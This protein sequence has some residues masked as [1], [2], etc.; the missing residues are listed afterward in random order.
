MSTESPE[1]SAPD[2][3]TGSEEPSN[4]IRGWQSLAERRGQELDA[5]RAEAAA[6]KAALAAYEREGT[7]RQLANEFP[8]AYEA[9]ATRKGA[10]GP[11][12]R[13]TLEVLQATLEERPNR[14]DP[15]NP[16]KRP[17]AKAP[18]QM[19]E[20]ELRALIQATA[21]AQGQ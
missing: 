12:D 10:V 21:G 11:E 16:P 20:A 5:A 9:L 17:I 7:V 18:S 15:N 19:S 1:Q 13:M 4:A 14:I 6:A 3:T 2:G 8:D